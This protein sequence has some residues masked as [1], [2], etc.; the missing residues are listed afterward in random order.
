[1]TRLKT[2]GSQNQ[3]LTPLN[4]Y[5]FDGMAFKIYS[6]FWNA[7]NLCLFLKMKTVNLYFLL[8]FQNLIIFND[9]RHM[10]CISLNLKPGHNGARKNKQIRARRQ[11]VTK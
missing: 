6:S 5:D 3:K 2:D 1:M 8:G 11:L 4:Q 7:I 10:S 9:A